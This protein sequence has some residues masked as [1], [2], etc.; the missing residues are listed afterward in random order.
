MPIQE[1]L[2]L[3]ALAADLAVPLAVALGSL[4][5]F[6]VLLVLQ[7]Q[8]VARPEGAARR[9]PLPRLEFRVQSRKHFPLHQAPPATAERSIA[10]QRRNHARLSIRTRPKRR[11]IHLRSSFGR[12]RPALLQRGVL[13]GCAALALPRFL[14]QA[15]FERAAARRV[16]L[17]ILERFSGVHLVEA[18][19]RHARRSSFF[20]RLSSFLLRLLF[21]TASA[22]AHA[23]SRYLSA[24]DFAGLT[25]LNA[26]IDPSK[27]LEPSYEGNEQKA[28]LNFLLCFSVLAGKRKSEGK[29]KRTGRLDRN[30]TAGML[31]IEMHEMADHRPP[32]QTKPSHN[33]LI[34]P[35]RLATVVESRTR[36]TSPLI[37]EDLL[38]GPPAPDPP[39]GSPG[40]SSGAANARDASGRFVDSWP[41]TLGCGKLQLRRAKLK[42][43][44]A[45]TQDSCRRIAA[46]PLALGRRRT[47]R[48]PNSG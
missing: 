23:R 43:L 5:P 20:Q 3:E 15:L 2:R 26:T 30:R 44:S 22:S 37:A 14:A 45:A 28:M 47:R 36:S 7:Q 16:D 39:L 27:P 9:Q 41:L 17:P 10:A 24:I 40:A 38:S 4:S 18:L 1:E 13:T 12:I 21:A 11:P 42:K 25:H 33:Q 6:L 19:W 32:G 29:R 34:K 8:V 46:A 35:H 48:G 31:K